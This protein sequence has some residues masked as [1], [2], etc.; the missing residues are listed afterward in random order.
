VLNPLKLV[1]TNWPAGEVEWIDA[2]YWPHDVPQQGTRPVPFSGELYIEADDF[3]EDPPKGFFRLSPGR[4]VRLRYG[5]IIR[6][7]DVVRDAAGAVVEVRCSYDPE[8]KGGSAAGRTVK[9]TLHWVSAAHALPCE[10]RLYDRLFSVPDP[11]AAADVDFRTQLN[12]ASL[13]VAGDALVEPS[14]AGDA[15]DAR[16]QFERLGYFAADP[17]DSRPDRLVY[18][19]IVTLRDTWAKVSAEGG[20]R[21]SDGRPDRSGTKA[22]ARAAAQPAAG[23]RAAGGAAG[24]T[25][26]TPAREPAGARAER[27]PELEQ[28]RASYEAL[29]V[30]QEQADV[31]TRD[32]AIA[33]LFD[34]ALLASN[35]AQA[36]AKWVV[37]EMPREARERA[38]ELPLSGRALGALVEL[39]EAGDISSSAGREVLAELLERGGEPA[40]IVERRGLRQLS[41]E[42]A[43][44]G[45]VS[46]VLEANGAKVAEY[47]GGRQGLLGFFIGQV[48]ARTGG[49][50]NPGVVRD[51]V[52]EQLEAGPTGG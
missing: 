43:L 12:P 28:K 20:Q 27:S 30:T 26:Q 21:P 2:S 32:A 35:R 7:D 24:A 14:V 40:E 22:A 25:R 4:E 23:E 11:E 41:D 16:Y 33:A 52:L 13:V 18:N 36:V 45:V 37:N 29:G 46:Q 6:C 38:G 51:L 10:V 34:G 19:R 42:G 47:R 31:L 9:G 17:L 39:V 3:R 15:T 50:A 49:R 44:R 8:T 48:M 1:I 5:Y